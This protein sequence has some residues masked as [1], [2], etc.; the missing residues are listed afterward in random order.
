MRVRDSSFS[1]RLNCLSIVTWGPIHQIYWFITGAK[2][3]FELE[4]R[5]K[6]DGEGTGPESY[7][8]FNESVNIRKCVGFSC[9]ASCLNWARI[10]VEIFYRQKSF[11]Y[12]K[13]STIHFA[14]IEGKNH[15]HSFNAITFA[16]LNLWWMRGEKLI[17]IILNISFFHCS[18]NP[19]NQSIE[20]NLLTCCDALSGIK[21]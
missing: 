14:N 9:T 10:Y 20:S 13:T 11:V 17:G 2:V 16:N 6:E 7:P 3:L 18:T 19:P 4:A 15:I 1:L 5:K 12:V 8:E 21:S